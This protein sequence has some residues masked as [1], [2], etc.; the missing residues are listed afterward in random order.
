MKKLGEGRVRGRKE[1]EDG[2][3]SIKKL[4]NQEKK[5]KKK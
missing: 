3:I 4:D 5:R 2:E 1:K